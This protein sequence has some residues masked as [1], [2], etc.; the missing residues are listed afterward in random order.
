MRSLESAQIMYMFCIT[1]TWNIFTLCFSQVVVPMT[2]ISTKMRFLEILAFAFRKCWL[3]VY[4]VVIIVLW[5][6]TIFVIAQREGCLLKLVCD[7]IALCIFASDIVV[8]ILRLVAVRIA[9]QYDV[10]FFGMKV[11]CLCTLGV[12]VWHKWRAHF[13]FTG[14]CIIGLLDI[15]IRSS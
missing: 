4:F 11:L 1:V 9:A 15:E 7:R 13:G 3:I 5:D 2:F 8:V 14:A 10:I 6:E 12:S